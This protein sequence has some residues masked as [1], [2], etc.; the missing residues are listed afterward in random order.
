VPSATRFAHPSS[1]PPFGYVYE[2][3]HKGRTLTFQAPMRLGLM[4][5]LKEWHR[6][7][8]VEWPGDA[9]MWERVVA[10]ICDRAPPGFCVG[11]APRVPF[12]SGPRLRDAT[13]LLLNAL[14]RKPMVSRQEADRRAR[15]CANCTK[16]LHGICTSCAGN[17]FL[18]LFQGL[19]RRGAST[20]YDEHLDSCSVC[21]CLLKAKVHIPLDVLEKLQQHTYPSN[22]WLHGTVA[23]RPGD[24]ETEKDASV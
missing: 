4:G 6:T 16:N 10:F 13:R 24:A 12:L 20:P 15:A 9:A 8:G 14:G 19:L 17:E 22:C 11:T 23:H 18:D 5:Q 3:E 1:V 7:H 2:F 21:G